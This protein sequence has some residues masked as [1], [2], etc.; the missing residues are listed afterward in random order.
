MDYINRAGTS[1]AILREVLGIESTMPEWATDELNNIIEKYS[2]FD[3]SKANLEL[4][5]GEL[6]E[7]GLGDYIPET[8]TRVIEENKADE[9]T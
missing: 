8:I 4:L 7:I 6:S 3:L 2:K 5:R 9:E 1:N